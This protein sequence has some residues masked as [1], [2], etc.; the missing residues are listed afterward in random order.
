MFFM[1]DLYFLIPEVIAQIFIL[2]AEFIMPTGTQIKVTNA[3]IE[4]QPVTIE[5]K[6]IKCFTVLVI[7]SINIFEFS[8]DL[9]L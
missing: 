1:I 2:T 8:S 9:I 6:I 3:E 5:A 4:T 7:P